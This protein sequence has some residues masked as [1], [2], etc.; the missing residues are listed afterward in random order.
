MC[1]TVFEVRVRARQVVVQRA[2]EARAR[3]RLGRVADE[4]REQAA[5]RVAA[6]VQRLAGDPLR[7]VGGERR[8]V[9][10][11]DLPALDRELRD[12]LDRVVL[13][14]GEARASAQV[15]QY[16]VADDQRDEQRERADGELA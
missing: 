13:P 1:S 10:G 11:E 2:L 14:V 9:G 15:C 7:P 5:L 12:A 3:A 6:Q 16:V 8:A 4:L